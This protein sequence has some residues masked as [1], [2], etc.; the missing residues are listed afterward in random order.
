MCI[1]DSLKR[2]LPILQTGQGGFKIQIAGLI[3]GSIG[4]SQIG[5]QNLGAARAHFQRLA[6][7]A[8]GSFETDGHFRNS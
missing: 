2:A 6:V 1:R 8:Q 4:V 3:I 5:R 7:D